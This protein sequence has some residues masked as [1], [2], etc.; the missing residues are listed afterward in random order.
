MELHVLL[1][2]ARSDVIDEASEA[3]GRSHST[4]YDRAGEG[5]TRQRLTD[6]YELVVT[7]IRSKDLAPVRAFAE[8]IASERFDA[9]FDIAEVQL[10]FNSLEAAMWHRVVADMPPHELAEAIGLLS[11]VLG[12]GKDTLARAYV[13][14]ASRKHVPS[15]DLTALFSGVES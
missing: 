6:L 9:G 8:N 13:S 2:E 11:T 1:V 5:L 12:F 3:L 14:L 4:H 15:L 7:A 10:A